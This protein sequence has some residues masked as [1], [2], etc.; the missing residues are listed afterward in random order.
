M[1]SD[2]S[3]PRCGA[4]EVLPWALGPGALRLDWYV[5]SL[6]LLFANSDLKFSLPALEASSF[7][8]TYALAQPTW[9]LSSMFILSFHHSPM[10]SM[11]SWGLLA[12]CGLWLSGGVLWSLTK[13]GESLLARL[14]RKSSM[15]Y[16]WSQARLS[17]TEWM[18]SPGRGHPDPVATIGSASF[19]RS[20]GH[21]RHSHR[22]QSPELSRS[23]S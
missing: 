3:S 18:T 19:P 4:S 23:C 6:P 16:P 7:P 12:L 15:D 11:Y 9:S 1:V 13:Q 17:V 10:D 2:D 20:L 14:L 22:L 8:T 21:P 5:S